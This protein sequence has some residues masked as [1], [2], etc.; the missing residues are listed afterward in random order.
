MGK[1]LNF[2][3][4]LSLLAYEFNALNSFAFKF[5]YSEKFSWLCAFQHENILK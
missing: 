2:C 3:L 1:V 4:R 5:A